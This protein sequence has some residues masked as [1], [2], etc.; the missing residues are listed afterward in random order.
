[1]LITPK[2]PPPIKKKD[3]KPIPPPISIRMGK[4]F[5]ICPPVKTTRKHY[6]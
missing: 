3:P 4:K 2:S 5:P 1:M 6:L